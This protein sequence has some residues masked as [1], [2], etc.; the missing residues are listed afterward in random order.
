MARHLGGLSW[1]ELSKRVGRDISSDKVLDR[2]AT[3]AFYFLLALFPL[4]I[5]II[6]ILGFVAHGTGLETGLVQWLTRTMPPSASGLVT[7]VVHETTSHAGGGKLSFGIV[8]ALWSAS[9]GMVAVIN[10]LNAAFDVK[11][12]RSW[13]RQ[14]FTALWLTVVM[15]ILMLV[16]ITIIL[17]G[18]RIVGWV[19]S[20]VG[21]STILQV[22]W[23][24]VQW[25]L[26]VGFAVLAF[27]MVYRY[28]PNKRN[29]RWKWMTPGALVGV[30]VWLAASFGFRVYLTYFNHYGATYGSLGTLI[31]LMMWFWVTAI[32][33]IVGGEIDSEVEAVLGERGPTQEPRRRGQGEF[34]AA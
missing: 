16:A 21:L 32:A 27:A 5:F 11:K 18:S 29:Q 24:V 8:L 15:G 20:A 13:I 23:Q 19:G 26:A 31:I 22:L 28:A 2:A 10:A 6:S 12:S 1:V 25:P 30:A 33:I 4:V 17:F 14:R 7:R 9:G 3:L 34:R